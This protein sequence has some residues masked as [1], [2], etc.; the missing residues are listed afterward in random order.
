M[1]ILKG[2]MSAR[3]F[4]V[5]GVPPEGFHEKYVAALNNHAFLEPVV[6]AGKE[7]LQGWTQFHNLLNT[8]FDDVSKWSYNQYILFSLRVDKKTLPANLFKATIGQQC[9]EWC[10]EHGHERVPRNVKEDFVEALEALWLKRML[11]RVTTTEVLWDTKESVV[12]VHAHAQKT[13][14]RITKRFYRTFGLELT[15]MSPLDRVSSNQKTT[16]LAGTT[17]TSFWAGAQ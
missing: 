14:D 3:R 16:A 5:L 17:P 7:E 6:P 1:G 10:A 12:Y 11:P 8:S 15:P 13:I 9:D 2:P 4:R